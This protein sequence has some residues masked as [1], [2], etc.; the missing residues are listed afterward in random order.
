MQGLRPE[1]W[2]CAQ[3]QERLLAPVGRVVVSME[4][5]GVPIDV[6]VL[7]QIRADMEQ[8]AAELR[9]QLLD[10]TGGRD[11][12]WNSWKQLAAWL[13]ND[14]KAPEELGGPGLGLPPSPY[15]KKGEVPDGE[16]KTDDKAL[17][18]I[19]GHSDEHRG[20]ITALRHLRQCE[21]M[22]R[23][24]RD[25]LAAAIP[26][27]DGT[28]RLHPSFGLG[29]DTDVRPGASTGRFG[30]KNPALNQ[31]PRQKSKDPAGMRRA[32]IPPPGKR[33]VVVDYSQLEVFILAHLCAQKFTGQLAARLKADTDL[34]CETARFVW[35]EV[36][37][38]A[39]VL[40][41]PVHVD[42]WKADK[43]LA[44]RR[45]L[46]KAVRYGK[47]YGKGIRGFATSIFLPDGTPLGLERAALLSEGLD[48]F[49]PEVPAYQQFVR[50]FIEREALITSPFGRWFPLPHARHH[51]LGMRNRAWRQALNYPMQAG[52]QEIMAL[53]IIA[54]TQDSI[55]GLLRDLG[56]E[57]ALV[58]HDETVG[59][60]DEDKADEA[61][62]RVNELMTSVVELLAPLK[63]EGKTGPNWSKCK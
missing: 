24:A 53:A 54:I 37:G 39:R 12:N 33:L 28:V 18:W 58:V 55:D 62:V 23:Y 13:H 5:T 9:V 56:Y 16:I 44:E 7:R 26:H 59:W 6:E 34:H 30:V 36:G 57:L 48:R 45:D 1:A 14:P 40:N 42:G 20:P 21:R 43:Y 11:V 27:D 4:R 46:T 52:G 38:D 17:E 29:S 31:V 61:Q 49:D 50:D 60:A 8:R 19:A 25:W 41:A 63:A 15:C 22:G 47:N 51:K 10:W 3:Y 2:T 35:G 32:F